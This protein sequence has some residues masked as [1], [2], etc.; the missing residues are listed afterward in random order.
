[1]KM[2]LDCLFMSP[3]RFI[4]AFSP[5]K[6]KQSDKDDKDKGDADGDDETAA[7][8]QLFSVV[9]PPKDR[10]HPRG[11]CV[12]VRGSGVLQ[13]DDGLGVFGSRGVTAILPL[14]PLQA[15]KKYFKSNFIYNEPKKIKYSG[16]DQFMTVFFGPPVQFLDP[17]SPTNTS[18]VTS[19]LSTL[20]F[21][22]CKQAAA[23][24][25]IK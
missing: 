8:A 12:G 5:Q 25:Q 23:M 3:T 16:P 10:P 9:R 11:G 18:C 19:T 17:K 15:K 7:A 22:S 2:L 1:M 20:D 21:W 6:N 14:A 13:K 24:L 4:G